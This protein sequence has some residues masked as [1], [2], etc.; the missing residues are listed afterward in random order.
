MKWYPTPG[1]H[2]VLYMGGGFLDSVGTGAYLWYMDTP[3]TE[4]PWLDYV[5]YKL[6]KDWMERAERALFGDF[7]CGYTEE[8]LLQLKEGTHYTQVQDDYN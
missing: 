6:H 3:Q 7:H 2:T 5:D 8:E 1:I 4:T